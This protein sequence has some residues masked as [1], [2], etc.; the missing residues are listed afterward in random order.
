VQIAYYAI[1]FTQFSMMV[2]SVLLAIGTYTV[3]VGAPTRPSHEMNNLSSLSQENA[4]LVV[5][6][7]IG[8]LTFMS[9]EALGLVYANV[10]KDQIFGVMNRTAVVVAHSR[11]ADLNFFTRRLACGQRSEICCS[12]AAI[13]TIRETK[14]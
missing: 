1:I 4:G 11:S 13:K 5:P 9:F 6:F 7:L 3:S 12:S 14:A 2:L 10:L 8:M